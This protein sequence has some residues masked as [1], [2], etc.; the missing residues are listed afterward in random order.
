MIFVDLCDVIHALSF[1]GIAAPHL[2]SKFPSSH[3]FFDFNCGPHT[4]SNSL[5]GQAIALLQ[6]LHS[7]PTTFGGSLWPPQWS[8]IPN[9]WLIQPPSYQG[10]KFDPWF[11]LVPSGPHLESTPNLVP[12][13]SLNWILEVLM[14]GLFAYSVVHICFFLLTHVHSTSLNQFSP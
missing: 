9:F 8:P 6:Q 1:W 2:I 5:A 14:C 10:F 4:L 13:L 12:F 3:Q 11:D 7:Q